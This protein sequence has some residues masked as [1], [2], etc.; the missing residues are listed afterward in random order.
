M[1][2]RWLVPVGIALAIIPLGIHQIP[3]GHVG[4]YYRYIIFNIE[5]V[6][7]KKTTYISI[8]LIEEVLF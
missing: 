6:Q 8:Y 5:Y 4:I 7:K 2:L 3:E 1:V